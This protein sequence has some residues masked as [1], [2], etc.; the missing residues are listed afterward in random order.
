MAKIVLIGSGSKQFGLG[1]LG[2]IFSSEA[3][4]H[5]TIMLHDIRE[6][7]LQEVHDLAKNFIQKHDLPFSVQSSTSRKTA[8]EHADYVIISI[9][10]G[11]RFALWDMDRTIPQQYGIRQVYGENGGAGGLFHSLRIIPPILDICKDVMQI[12]PEAFVFNYSNPM[13]RICTTVHA[14]FPR[15][16]FIGLCHEIASLERYLPAML[17]T[18]F[19]NL[20]LYAAGLNHF[21]CLLSARYKSR[22]RVPHRPNKASE[23]VRDNT[24]DHLDAYPDILAKAPQFFETVPS[25]TDYI[26]EVLK[27]KN[28]FQ[29]EGLLHIPDIPVE[30]PLAERHLCMYVLKT[31][32]LLPITSDSH[33]GEYLGW[34]YDVA[35]HKGILDFYY[36]YQRML[37][38]EYASH[39]IELTVHERVAPIMSGLESGK[40]FVEAAVNIPNITQD[41]KR[42]IQELPEW[43]AVEVPANIRYKSIEGISAPSLSKSYAALLQNQ[44][45]V[46]A[47][48]TEAVLTKSKKMV[49]HALLSDPIV[50]VARG[51]EDLIDA[52]ILR[53]Q[54]FLD[55]LA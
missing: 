51:L 38:D 18:A 8:L 45:A 11:D 9:E 36:Y 1:T 49:L 2:D 21:S 22:D 16:K 33:F 53:Q 12:C 43:I 19:D 4:Y 55:Y 7:E 42:L 41:G 39:N 48:T 46:H 24:R 40:E 3:L 25:Y 26:R 47:M 10:V 23:N 35:D 6:K 44:V 50:T 37:A 34:A 31:F 13:S 29:T 54:P 27:G 30:R 52:M 14:V 5:S 15:L 32:S 28:Y 17:N 20:E